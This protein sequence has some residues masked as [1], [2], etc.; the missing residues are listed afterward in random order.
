M[1]PGD[2]RAGE[3]LSKKD[4][5]GLVT[6]LKEQKR[7]KVVL[8]LNRDAL[9]GAADD[10]DE[11]IEK[12]FKGVNEDI[13]RTKSGSD[14]IDTLNATSESLICSLV[15]NLGFGWVVNDHEIRQC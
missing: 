8:L 5:L 1:Q 4:V 11:Q 6:Q 9:R 13:Y 15:H 3:G 2:G 12:V 14:L 10:F 7:C